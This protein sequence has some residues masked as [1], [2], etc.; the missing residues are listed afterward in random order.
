MEQSKSDFGM[1]IGIH[2]EHVIAKMYSFVKI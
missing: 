1:P 2:D